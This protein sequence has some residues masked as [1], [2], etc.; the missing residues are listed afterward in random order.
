LTEC[1]LIHSL[2]LSRFVLSL[3]KKHR[4][5]GKNQFNKNR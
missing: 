3:S 5:Q 2:S 4:G 1:R